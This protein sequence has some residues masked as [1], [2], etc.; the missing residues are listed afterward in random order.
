MKIG[1]LIRDK[2][3]EMGMSQMELADTVGT[4]TA[5]ISR[6]ES[7]GIRQM[8][9]PMIEATAKALNIDPVMLVQR[10]E[11]VFPDEAKVLDAYRAADDLT[12]AMVRRALQIE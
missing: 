8:K 6:W 1:D 5:T 10:E 3:I 2:R 12:K 4:T 9:R 7:G 11:V